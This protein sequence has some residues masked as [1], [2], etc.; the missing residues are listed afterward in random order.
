MSIIGG[1]RRVPHV[2]HTKSS[3]RGGTAVETSE[4][5]PSC[6]WLAA[7]AMERKAMDRAVWSIQDVVLDDGDEIDDFCEERKL[8]TFCW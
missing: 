7:E 4:A 5:S 3:H 2:R 6:S 1:N 8:H